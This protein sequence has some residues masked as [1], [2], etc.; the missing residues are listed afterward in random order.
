[1]ETDRELLELAAKAAQ[2]PECGW[3]G[4]AF[5][6]VEKNTF[7]EWNPLT[8]D[9]DLYRLA[10]AVKGNLYFSGRR[11]FFEIPSDSEEPAITERFEIGNHE[12]EALAIVRAAA[13]WV[14]GSGKKE[15]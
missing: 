5:M 2:L 11:G 4:P 8:D 14:L 13:M 7:T 12:E 9:G 3:M 6:Y 15:K 1:M 10:R